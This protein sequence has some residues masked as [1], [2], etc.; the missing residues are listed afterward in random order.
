MA[1]FQWLLSSAL[2]ALLLLARR[3]RRLERRRCLVECGHCGAEG[4]LYVLDPSNRASDGFGY[5]ERCWR[6][7][8]ER[9]GRRCFEEVQPRLLEAKPTCC[10]V[11]KASATHAA[12]VFAA[13]G[14]DVVWRCSPC[15]DSL[16]PDACLRS[17]P[18]LVRPPSLSATPRRGFVVASDLSF[19]PSGSAVGAASAQHR[20]LLRR[21]GCCVAE[22][23]DAFEAATYWKAHFSQPLPSL[24]VWGAPH[25]YVAGVGVAAAPQV[26]NATFNEV[27]LQALRRQFPSARVVVTFPGYYRLDDSFELLA[28][29]YA[30]LSSDDR[31]HQRLT[32]EARC[33]VEP[34]PAGCVFDLVAAL[35]DVLALDAS[36]LFLGEYDFFLSSSCI[37]AA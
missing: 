6:G 31:W 14:K 32:A 8:L 9:Q 20:A 5:C 10:A 23:V 3:R 24:I 30:P 1:S 36:V 28:P 15:R 26:D 13:L 35:R 29:G 18:P 25:P 7:H 12:P 4:R 27:A 33:L 17:P 34:P 2:A 16:L 19:V 11:C 37:V 21:L 22:G